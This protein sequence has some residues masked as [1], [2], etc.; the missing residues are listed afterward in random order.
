[1]R[2][3][4]P[5]S[6]PLAAPTPVRG[7]VLKARQSLTWRANHSTA[8][9]RAH[10]DAASNS[11]SDGIGLGDPNRLVEICRLDDVEPGDDL[12]RV[13]ERPGRHPLGPV[14]A[15]GTDGRAPQERTSVGRSPTGRRGRDVH[16]ST[17]T[18]TLV[19]ASSTTPS[20]S[21]FRADAFSGWF[22]RGGVRRLEYQRRCS[23]NV[24]ANR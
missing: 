1:M 2:R 12:P 17:S 3:L 16:G 13:E 11:A 15:T 23:S 22:P 10:L 7:L 5:L 19:P 8:V 6:C 14:L 18:P 20:S 24:S 21:L 9:H 4:V